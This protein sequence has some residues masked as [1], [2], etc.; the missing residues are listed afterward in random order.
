ML[1]VL[2]TTKFTTELFQMIFWCRAKG[3]LTTLRRKIALLETLLKDI[4]AKP[5]LTQRLLTWLNSLFIS[6]SSIALY[7]FS[8]ASI[9]L[10]KS[11]VIQYLKDQKI[12]CPNDDTLNRLI[13]NQR[14]KARHCIFDM[15]QSRLNT[16]TIQ[17]IKE[18]A[19]VEEEYS[20]LEGLKA[21][22]GRA[23]VDSLLSLTRKLELIKETGVLY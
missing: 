5:K 7:L 10:L 22:P 15:I 3:I 9:S 1:F 18:F 8:N 19:L 4:I 2:I 23:S 20:K 6:I 12:L 17:K 14:K 21:P 16:V 11:K 13:A